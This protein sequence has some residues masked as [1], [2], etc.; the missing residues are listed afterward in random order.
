[1]IV[2]DS[3]VWFLSRIVDTTMVDW[4]S[5]RGREEIKPIFETWYFMVWGQN[6]G[7]I[8]SL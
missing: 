4:L 1:M 5:P 7:K 3:G 6:G 8:R 2:I